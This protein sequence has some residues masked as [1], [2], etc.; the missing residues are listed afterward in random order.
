MEW[1]EFY[2]FVLDS[3]AH[4]LMAVLAS[5][6]FYLYKKRDIPWGFWGGVVIA[7]FGSLIIS[8]FLALG[9][10]FSSFLV[11]LLSPKISSDIYFR[12]NIL[13]S[14]IGAC[15]FLGMINWLNQDRERFK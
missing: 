6:Y 5:S 4:F 13:S 7:F 8:T 1:S 14:L 15:L 11:W 3:S 9:G 2:H 12:V 10:W